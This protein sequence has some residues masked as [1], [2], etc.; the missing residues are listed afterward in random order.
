MSRHLADHRSPSLGA[1]TREFLRI[2]REAAVLARAEVLRRPGRSPAGNRRV[3]EFCRIARG[4][5]A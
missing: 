3:M 5:S 1:R 4:R 2:D